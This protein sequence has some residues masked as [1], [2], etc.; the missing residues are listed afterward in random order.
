MDRG[1][2]CNYASHNHNCFPHLCRDPHK[3]CRDVLQMLGVKL[4]SHGQKSKTVCTVKYIQS[5]PKG[6]MLLNSRSPEQGEEILRI[7][8][9]QISGGGD[10]GRGCLPG[11]RPASLEVQTLGIINRG[12]QQPILN[13]FLEAWSCLGKHAARLNSFLSRCQT[14]KQGARDLYRGSILPEASN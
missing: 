8:S 4:N 11:S 9:T 2:R 7:E 6:G 14:K 13:A 1:K 3:R 10:G 12:S 5:N